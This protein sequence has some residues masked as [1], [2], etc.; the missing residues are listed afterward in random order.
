[1]NHCIVC[2]QNNVNDSYSSNKFVL[3][4]INM[5]TKNTIKGFLNACL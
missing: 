3:K 2:K 4:K 1:M 5:L